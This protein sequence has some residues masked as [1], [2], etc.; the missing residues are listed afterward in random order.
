M[1]MTIIGPSENKSNRR[2]PLLGEN[3]YGWTSFRRPLLPL[4]TTY[5]SPSPAGQCVV[6]PRDDAIPLT[7]LG[8]RV[9]N[10]YAVHEALSEIATVVPNFRVAKARND[11]EPG[12]HSLVNDV[13]GWVHFCSRWISGVIWN[14]LDRQICSPVR[15]Q[16]P[17]PI[18]RRRFSSIFGEYGG[19]N[20]N[21]N[22][23][24]RNFLKPA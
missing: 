21:S 4:S 8:S 11:E 19:W 5:P 12:R 6:N 22:A 15:S 20:V 10:Q 24:F 23:R 2:E 9:V 16:K 7:F 1:A 3:L 17:P 14:R 13:R 18:A